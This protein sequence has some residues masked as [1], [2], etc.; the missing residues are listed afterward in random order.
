MR[1]VAIELVCLIGVGA[2][3]FSI[4]QPVVRCGDPHAGPVLGGIDLVAAVDNAGKNVSQVKGD[5][6]VT[7]GEYNFM[8]TSTDNAAK[9]LANVS[10]YVPRYGG[11]CGIA[12]TGHDSCCKPMQYCL[13]PT[14][15]LQNGHWDSE[16]AAANLNAA[17]ND[18]ASFVATHRIP[19]LDSAHPDVPACFNTDYLWCLDPGPPLPPPFPQCPSSTPLRQP[20]PAPAP[21]PA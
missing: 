9:F 11:Y 13:G 15:T 8:F 14:C 1:L 18:W 17:N 10:A 12:M 21:A 6:R 4:A 19:P 20:A 16:G 7:L 2:A 3:S 5:L